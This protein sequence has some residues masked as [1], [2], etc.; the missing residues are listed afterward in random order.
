[1]AEG[2]QDIKEVAFVVAAA[3]GSAYFCSIALDYYTSHLG[4]MGAIDTGNNILAPSVVEKKP[5]SPAY[6]IA[7]GIVFAGAMYYGWHY[8]QK[9]R[10]VI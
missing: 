1:M 9:N 5:I 6:K 4:S 3:I 7:G 10:K 8:I 2:K